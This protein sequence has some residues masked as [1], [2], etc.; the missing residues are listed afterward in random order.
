VT[1]WYAILISGVS[2]AIVTLLGVVVGGAITGRSQRNQWLRDK[3]IDA[4]AAV[5]RES[6]AMQITLKG[7]WGTVEEPLDW[8]SWN[9]AL[10]TIW[11]VATPA[12]RAEAKRMDR[13]FWLC[14]ARM[15]RE[16]IANEVVWAELRDEMELSR[17]DLINAAR[18]EVVATR[19]LVADVPV[20]RPSLA[21][22]SEIFGSPCGPTPA[23]RTD[24]PA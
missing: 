3:Q 4:C 5:I 18:H 19:D 23:E 2:G 10:A 24:A 13:L 1:T 15:K 22:L 21:E 12:V 9:Q 17:R 6:T 11:L 20:A 16:Q 8:T 7:R 14:Q